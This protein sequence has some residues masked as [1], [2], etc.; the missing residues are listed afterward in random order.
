M[1]ISE[2]CFFGKAGDF[3]TARELVIHGTNFEIGRAVAGLAIERYGRRRADFACDP[4]FGHARR[5]YMQAHFPIH[6][7]RMRGVA[8]VL[9]VDAEDDGYDLTEIAYL[10]DTPMQAPGCSAVYYPPAT[11]TAGTG[12]L[13]RNYDFSIDSM[14]S[15]MRSSLPVEERQKARPV[16]SEPY[17]MIWEPTDGGYATLAVHAFDLLSGTLEGINSTGLVVSILAD[18]TAIIELG[19]KL[20]RHSGPAH[21]VGLNEL[22]V[23]RLLLD[24]CSTAAQ[25]KETLLGIKQYYGFAPLHYIIADR[26]GNSFV[27]EDSTGRNRQYVID[28]G[29]RPQVLTNFQIHESAAPISPALEELDVGNETYWRHRQLADRIE[30]R[31]APF[32]T[33]E[34]KSAN[35]CVS[36]GAMMNQLGP[37]H[38]LRNA[39]SRTI[40][41]SLYDQAAGSV[42]MS[43][44]LGEV[45]DPDGTYRERRSDYTKFVIDAK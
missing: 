14:A 20:E 30:T 31:A 40:W 24:T 29:G 4:V 13:S 3:L 23:M 37:D 38:P 44:Y 34:M 17:I 5:K 9:G 16:M 26:S 8:D 10:T 1:S 21:A 7:E 25:A 43:F 36:V 12:F 33:A 2:H 35:A 42:E 15:F 19:P 28:G 41:H 32:T 18:H 11:T 45:L 6:W 22:A 39:R 27:Y